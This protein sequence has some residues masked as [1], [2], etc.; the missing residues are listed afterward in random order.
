MAFP[1]LAQAR[2][3]RHGSPSLSPVA[4]LYRRNS[5]T[6]NKKRYRANTPMKTSKSTSARISRAN[7]QSEIGFLCTWRPGACCG[8]HVAVSPRAYAT[9]ASWPDSSTPPLCA[10]GNRRNSDKSSSSFCISSC[11]R[12]LTDACA[13]VRRGCC[14][15][16]MLNSCVLANIQAHRQIQTVPNLVRV[17]RHDFG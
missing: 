15:F 3:A 8:S 1:A 10:R 2:A 13:G 16:E 14:R 5:A 17:D 4:S 12:T 11:T 7:V 6:L 9:R